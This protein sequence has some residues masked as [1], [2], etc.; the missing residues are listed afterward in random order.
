MKKSIIITIIATLMLAILNGC[1]VIRFE[2]PLIKGEVK[3]HIVTNSEKLMLTQTPNLTE[4]DVLKASLAKNEYEGMQFV[5][6]SEK[7]IKNLSVSMTE[8]KNDNGEKLSFELYRQHYIEVNKTG[9]TDLEPGFYP[10][11][12]IPIENENNSVNIKSNENQGFWITV[13]ADKNATPGVY[14][15]T[16]KLAHD[17]GILET[18]VSVEVWNFAIPETPSFMSAF[19]LWFGTTWGVYEKK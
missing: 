18:R 13:Y 14:T 17:G 15:A 19:S 6:R 9:N 7:D 10:D 2:N 5:V 12:L 4:K 16:I 1:T 11:A 8:L 3:M